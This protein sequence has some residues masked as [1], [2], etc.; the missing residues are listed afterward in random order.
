MSLIFGIF[1]YFRPILIVNA[2]EE[3]ENEFNKENKSI[4]GEQKELSQHMQISAKYPQNSLHL[5]AAGEKIIT[6]ITNNSS[7]IENIKNYDNNNTTPYLH[8][9]Q[10]IV[11]DIIS[12]DNKNKS[13]NDKNSPI[14]VVGAVE[15]TTAKME[16]AADQTAEKN[17]FLEIRDNRL[18][19]G[20]VKSEFMPDSSSNS[21][22][23]NGKAEENYEIVEIMSQS[24]NTP[25]SENDENLKTQSQNERIILGD[26]SIK[27]IDKTD[28]L[29]KQFCVDE[30]N[31]SSINRNTSN[32]PVVQKL[33][34]MENGEFFEYIGI[35]QSKT[36]F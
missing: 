29:M 11:N 3:N 28:D 8:K 7:A 9:Q 30:E 15:K 21:Q 34:S 19:N 4:N 33:D 22:K 20:N 36:K 18:S 5:P 17:E 2:A 23:M 6:A 16:I 13:D 24:T 10:N 35:P 12:S 32:E 1:L 26:E 31:D 27:T 14:I 25:T